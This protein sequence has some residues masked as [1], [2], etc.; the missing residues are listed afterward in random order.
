MSEE[1]AMRASFALRRT[2]ASMILVSGVAGSAA[3]AEKMTL[4]H[5]GLDR[6]LKAPAAPQPDVLSDLPAP[7]GVPALAALPKPAPRARAQRPEL[8]DQVIVGFESGDRARARL[9]QVRA[10]CMAPGGKRAAC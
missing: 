6:V 10:R 4:H 3:A 2:L 5:E 9:P 1:V 8:N 7:P